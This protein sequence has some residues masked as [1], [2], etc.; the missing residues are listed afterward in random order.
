MNRQVKYNIKIPQDVSLIYSE[1]K[2]TLTVL[3]PLKKKSIKLKLKTFIDK[4]KKIISISHL[5]FSKISNAEKKKIKTLRLTTVTQ[6]K[7]LLIESSITIFQKL[8][9]IGVGYRT[10]FTEIF[11]KKLLTLKLGYS[12]LLYMRIPKNL[13]IDCSTKTKFCIFGNSYNEVNE[14]SARIRSKKL[15]EPYKGKGILYENETV[16]LKEGKKI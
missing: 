14:F 5:L 15:P 13:S 7:H 2:K 1:K 10:D 12:H 4:S 16:F 3:G 9:I 8:K 11:K 6:I